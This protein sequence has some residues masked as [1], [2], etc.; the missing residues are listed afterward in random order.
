ML[1]QAETMS[2]T[3][4]CLPHEWQE[5]EYFKQSPLLHRHNSRELDW[6][7]EVE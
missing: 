6:N 4:V 3:S 5:S 7:S 2:Q 1:G